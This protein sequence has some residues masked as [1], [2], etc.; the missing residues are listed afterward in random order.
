LSGLSGLGDLVLTAVSEKSRNYRHGLALGRGELPDPGVT[1]EG[2]ATTLALARAAGGLDLP[3]TA[4]L[5]RLLQ[6]EI[7]VPEAMQTLLSR[8]L[9]SE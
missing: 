7:T 5:A 3:I 4:I 9:K 6:G 8:P 2:V 1:V